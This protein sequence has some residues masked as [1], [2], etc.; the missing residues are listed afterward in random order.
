MI[1]PSFIK[2]IL[3]ILFE[4]NWALKFISITYVQ[5]KFNTTPTIRAAHVLILISSA[6]MGTSNHLSRLDDWDRSHSVLLY[7]VYNHLKDAL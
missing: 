5:E 1:Q 4:Y 3:G 2:S 6:G 7:M